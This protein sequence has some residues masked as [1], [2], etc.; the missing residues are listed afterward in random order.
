MGKRA[1]ALIFL[2]LF[3]L[4]P[5]VSLLV[6]AETAISCQQ[7]GTQQ[8]GWYQNEQLIMNANCSGCKAAC[9]Y[10]GTQQEGWYSSC[11]KSLIKQEVCLVNCYSDTN[12]PT[13]TYNSYCKELQAC[14][15]TT[16]HKCENAGTTLSKCVA[17][18]STISCTD[19]LYG[20]SEGTCKSQEPQTLCIDSDSED[21]Y[22]KGYVKTESGEIWDS[23]SGTQLSEGI[24]LEGRYD[25]IA[26]ACLQGCNDGKCIKQETWTGLIRIDIVESICETC[27]STTKETPCR[28]DSVKLYHAKIHVYDS[29]GNLIGSG[30]TSK[31]YAEFSGLKEGRYSAKLYAEGYTSDKAEI[32]LGPNIGNH[33]TITLKRAGTATGNIKIT[34]QDKTTGKTLTNAKVIVQDSYGTSVAS[35]DT[36]AGSAVIYSLKE[37]KYVA[38]AHASDYNKNKAE[39]KIIG[40]ESDYL[41][42]GLEPTQPT[43]TTPIPAI[44]WYRNAYWQC[45]D[46]YEEKS[47]GETS[48]KPAEV[49]KNYAKESCN[50]RCSNETEKCGINSFKIYN[51]C[52][53]SSNVQPSACGNGICESGEGEICAIAMT[54]CE[55]G[56]KCEAQSTKKCYYGCELDCKKTK[57]EYMSVRLNEKFKM[58]MSQ[59][60]KFE[61]LPLE[62]KFNDLFVPK[63]A[64]AVEEK[65]AAVAQPVTAVSTTKTAA[66]TEKYVAV[67]EKYDT[68]TG[69][70][71]MSSPLKQGNTLPQQTAQSTATSTQETA[72]QTTA[73]VEYSIAKCT[74]A[75]PYAVLQIKLKDEK[76]PRTEVIKLKVGEKRRVIDFTIGLLDYDINSKTGLFVVSKEAFECPENCVCDFAGNVTECKKIEKCPKKTRLC[77]DGVCREKCE[78]VNITTECKFGCF[79]NEKCLPY[80]LRI[81]KLYC[82]IDDNMKSQMEEE[83]ACENNFECS[84]NVCVNG[85]C[86]SAGMIQSVISWFRKLFGG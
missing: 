60:A 36:S 24:C 30:D 2:S 79:Y 45:Y 82:S 41:T 65:N 53:G 4:L 15:E 22:I 51:E 57:E 56:K 61:D 75:E 42:I 76:N 23:C 40:S 46:G 63:C 18:P 21:Y 19:C 62:I 26:Y 64:V 81:N 83:G 73:R 3:F 20:C 27:T 69:N 12:C 43:S 66:V 37:G 6:S 70:V 9:E 34:V 47:G 25:R 33:Y 85:K 58:Q 86:I 35:A 71:I 5:L 74:D 49:W 31:G 55:I 28:C 1:F 13:K 77:P 50:E 7:I 8:E 17:S 52:P 32:N 29:S 78:V 72:T 10:T 16:I 84:T 59:I 48:C 11:D 14:T 39:F 38:I 68:L 80:G 67:I 54:T 44:Y